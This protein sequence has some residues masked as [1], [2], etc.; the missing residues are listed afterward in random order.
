MSE[1][2][3]FADVRVGGHGTV[4]GRGRAAQMKG[5]LA[6]ENKRNLVACYRYKEGASGLL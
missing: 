4:C 6:G 3:P 2:G 1:K 5:P